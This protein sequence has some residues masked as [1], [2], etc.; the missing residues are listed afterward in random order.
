MSNNDFDL[1]PSWNGAIGIAVL[2]IGMKPAASNDGMVKSRFF[3]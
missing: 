3:T 2:S 1:P